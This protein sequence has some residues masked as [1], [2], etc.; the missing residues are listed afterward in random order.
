[1]KASDVPED[2]VIALIRELGASN[3]AKWA[4]LWDIQGRLPQFPPK[5]VKAKL[6]AMVKRGVIGGC[7]CGCRGDFHIK[8]ERKNT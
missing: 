3:A 6:A 1:M 8:D 5:V 7:G 2:T 4:F